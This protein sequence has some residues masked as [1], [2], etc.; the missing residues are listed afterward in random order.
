MSNT[1]IQRAKAKV[2]DSGEKYGQ[3]R[4]KLV[5][6]RKAI[7]GG[8]EQE[9]NAN[10]CARGQKSVNCSGNR[11]KRQ[12]KGETHLAIKIRLFRASSNFAIKASLE[13]T[14]R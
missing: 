2:L 11:R 9:E 12:A 3:L 8:C 7:G 10:Y 6:S 4:A 13:D 5:A 1:S 14:S